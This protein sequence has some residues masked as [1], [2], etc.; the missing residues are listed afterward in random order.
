MATLNAYNL[1]LE[2]RFIELDS[3]NWVQYE[4]RFLYKDE[5]MV[6]DSQLK[7]SPEHWAK[8][9]PGAFKANQYGQDGFLPTLWRLI[10]EVWAHETLDFPGVFEYEVISSFG[11]WLGDWLLA[12]EG[13]L[14][15]P[16][17][18]EIKIRE[19]IAAFFDDSKREIWRGPLQRP[20]PD[21]AMP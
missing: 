2:I 18:A 9:S 17:I 19:L 11:E 10:A 16:A 12:H 14:P 15:E 8:R 7:R 20:A 21:S 4:I 6:V 5:P 1:G 13:R 3:N